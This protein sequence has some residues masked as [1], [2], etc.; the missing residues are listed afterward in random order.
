MASAT[1]DPN[2]WMAV[3][4]R[5]ELIKQSQER[6]PLKNNTEIISQFA[7]LQRFCQCVSE[8]LDR[9]GKQAA[10]HLVLITIRCQLD[11]LIQWFS[12]EATPLEGRFVVWIKRLTG[13]YQ[14][15]KKIDSFLKTFESLKGQLNPTEDLFC[16][17]QAETLHVLMQE[18]ASLLA[19]ESH[20]RT[21]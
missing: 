6:H 21:A 13:T 9:P 5:T 3:L 19:L 8:D 15:Q 17:R 20:L 11:C 2:P 10:E 16:T 1:L 4:H 14:P 12:E 18:H 7:Q